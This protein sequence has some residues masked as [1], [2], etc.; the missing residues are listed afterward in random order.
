MSN[1][2]KPLWCAALDRANAALMSPSIQKDPLGY[3]I[4]AVKRFTEEQARD[5]ATRAAALKPP[6]YAT[7]LT[8]VEEK[9]CREKWKKQYRAQLARPE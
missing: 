1:V 4:G 8:D 3:A 2:R 6:P 5:Q 9:E 7:G